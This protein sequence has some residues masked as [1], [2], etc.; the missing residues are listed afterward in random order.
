MLDPHILK[1]LIVEDE[2]IISE[3]L[4]QMLMDMNYSDITIANTFEDGKDEVDRGQFDLAILDINLSG[5]HE[6]IVLGTQCAKIKKPFFF[7]TSYADRTTISS[8]RSAKPGAYI[9]KPFNPQ[10]ILVGI[11]MTLMHQESAYND[12]LR[13]LAEGLG[14][15]ER[16]TEIL[17][18]LAKRLTNA[19]ISEKLCVSTNTVKYHLKRL[20]LKL[21][22]VNRGDIPE[23][24]AILKNEYS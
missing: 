15:T 13:K 2:L 7:L 11:E 24:L 19:E 6:G 3:T 16:E 4:R 8:A 23:R 9:L 10:E 12:D 5:G 21:G 14:L 22:I 20:Y 17:A 1:I 18:L